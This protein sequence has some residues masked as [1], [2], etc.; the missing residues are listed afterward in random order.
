M[1]K[2]GFTLTTMMSASL[3]GSIEP[4]SRPLPIACALTPR[5]RRDRAGGRHPH[6]D[7]DLDAPMVIQLTAT[8]KARETMRTALRMV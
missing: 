6:V 2:F 1:S 4:S 7:V 8:T 5:R 3:P